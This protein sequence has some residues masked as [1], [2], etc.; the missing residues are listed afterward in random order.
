M[1]KVGSPTPLP[2]STPYISFLKEHSYKL[3]PD[4]VRTLKSNPAYDS[5]DVDQEIG[6][7]HAWISVHPKR[8]L[9]KRFV[10]NWLNRNCRLRD[11]TT[12]GYVKSKPQK[13]ML[14]RGGFKGVVL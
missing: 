1:T 10:V 7:M 13:D 12:G 5:L 2:S 4:F 14:G 3:D 8:K 6:K 11:L 9:T